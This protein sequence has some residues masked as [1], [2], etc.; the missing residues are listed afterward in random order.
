MGW[1]GV[2]AGSPLRGSAVD[3]DQVKGVLRTEVDSALMFAYVVSRWGAAL[4][5]DS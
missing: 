2:G 4:A 1:N 5:N 3:D